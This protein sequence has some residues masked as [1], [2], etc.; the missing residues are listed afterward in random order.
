MILPETGSKGDL[1]VTERLQTLLEKTPPVHDA[2]TIVM[3]F[4][5]GVSELRSDDTEQ[6]LVKR[7][8][9]ALYEAKRAGRERVSDIE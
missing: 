1:F 3:T 9:A 4:S 8:D 7:A 5:A 6:T 2:K